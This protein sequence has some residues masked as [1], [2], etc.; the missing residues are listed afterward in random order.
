VA[1]LGV[2]IVALRRNQVAPLLLAI[3][4]RAQ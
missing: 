1:L 3:R 2:L 4:N